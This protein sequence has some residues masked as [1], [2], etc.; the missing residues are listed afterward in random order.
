MPS[1]EGTD[2]PAGCLGMISAQ[3][4]SA[5]NLYP[6]RV[7]DYRVIYQ[8]LHHPHNH[9][10]KIPGE[11]TTSSGRQNGPGNFQPDPGKIFQP[12]SG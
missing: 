4:A 2:N 5:E 11:T 7:G 1:N 9:H 8:V 12:R 3:R 6:I 10:E